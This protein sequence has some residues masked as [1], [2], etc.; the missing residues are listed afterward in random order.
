MKNR[1]C[2]N[3]DMCRDYEVSRCD[4]CALGEKIALIIRQNKKLK[5]EKKEAEYRAEVA[6]LAARLLALTEW[7]YEKAIANAKYDL[8]EKGKWNTKG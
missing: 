8:A 3:K 1:N 4:G 6:D 2:P 5:A 7:E